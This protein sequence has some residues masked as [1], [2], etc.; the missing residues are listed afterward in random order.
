MAGVGVVGVAGVSGLPQA[1]DHALVVA[2][3]TAFLSEDL[4][5]SA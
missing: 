2:G 3:L 1:E 5:A 4:P